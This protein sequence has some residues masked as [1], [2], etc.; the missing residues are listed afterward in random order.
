MCGHPARCS[1]AA[2]PSRAFKGSLGS[3][4]RRD[5][6]SADG[7]WAAAPHTKRAVRTSLSQG[8]RLL[9]RMSVRGGGGYGKPPR[10]A[11]RPDSPPAGGGQGYRA[12]AWKELHSL[13][14]HN[15][16]LPTWHQTDGGRGREPTE[17][18][19]SPI[20]HTE[21]QGPEGG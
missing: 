1:G 19:P 5:A 16:G 6:C 15:L 2:A 8:T 7:L 10:V 11:F 9:C 12:A 3:P 21:K 20:P 14:A 17:A 18:P 13:C 4:A